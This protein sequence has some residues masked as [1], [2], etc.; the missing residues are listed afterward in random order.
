MF[1]PK[2]LGSLALIYIRANVAHNLCEN[3]HVLWLL[4]MAESGNKIRKYT[5]K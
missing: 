3:S 1:S 4:S 5:I 2:I